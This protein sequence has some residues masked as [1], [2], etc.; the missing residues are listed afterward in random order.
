MGRPEGCSTRTQTAAAAFEDAGRGPTAKQGGR[1]L[2]AESSPWLT[3]SKEMETSVLQP[4]GLDS[5]NNLN[6]LESQFILSL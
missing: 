5:A 1:P 6:E 3:V 2:A 4:Q